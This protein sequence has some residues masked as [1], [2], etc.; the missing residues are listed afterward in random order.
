M[1]KVTTFGYTN[2]TASSHTLAPTLLGMTTNYSL[3]QDTA[4]IVR[5]NNK[6]APIDMEEII[7]VRSRDIPEVST[8]CD[9]ANP[10]FAKKAIEYGVRN[11]VI[12]TTTDTTDAS[13][14]VDEPIVCSISI[15]HPKSGNITE[16]LVAE[17]LMR[18]LSGFVK[19]DGTWRI[20]DLMRSSERPIE[21]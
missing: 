3:M 8:H 21:D 9:V 2:N 15:K 20:G 14:R 16:A 13:F 19:A 10:T 5:L 7:T 17:T 11:D 12:V 18:T 6:T 4:D 1:S